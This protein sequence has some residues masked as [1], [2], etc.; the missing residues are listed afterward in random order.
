LPGSKG[1]NQAAAA[2][3]AGARVR[4]AS[5]VGLNMFADLAL[6]ALKVHQ[7]RH[8]RR[9]PHRGCGRGRRLHLRR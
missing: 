2:A 8:E 4:F 6:D 7:R 9:A 3:K 5:A 1:A